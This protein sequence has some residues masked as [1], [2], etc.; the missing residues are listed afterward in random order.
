VT[1]AYSPGAKGNQVMNDPKRQTQLTRD[2]GHAPDRIDQLASPSTSRGI[3]LEIL[4]SPDIMRDLLQTKL[5][6]VH[7]D[8]LILGQCRPKVLKKHHTSSY[9]IAYTLTLLNKGGRNA[10]CLDLI[11]K[12]YANGAMGERAYRTLQV[13]QVRGFGNGSG[14]NV[15]TPLCYFSDLKLLIQES[16]CGLPLR[17]YLAWNDSA[18]SGRMRMVAHWLAKLHQIE[19][20]PEGIGCHEE[21]ESSLQNVAYRLG[22][23]Y[24]H[25]AS[26]LQELASSTWQRIACFK[27]TIPSVMVHGDFHPANI[28][29]TRNG[30]TVIDF[31][32]FRRSDPARDLGNIIVQM[33]N[34]AYFATGSLEASNPEIRAFLNAYFAAMSRAAT[35]ALAG[36]IVAFAALTFLESMCYISCLRGECSEILSTVP[37]E[38]DRFLRAATVGDIVE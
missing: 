26:R 14:L 12:A 10:R 4:T 24:P 30:V 18:A 29:V 1:R 35:E 13:L 6:K 20:I 27:N 16:V 32:Q 31:D 11:G 2:F 25:L 21:D 8:G 19:A 9:V 17:Q 36:R 23:Q 3:A 34:M 15:P 38:V 7:F 37:A 33:R 28:V 22:E 5:S